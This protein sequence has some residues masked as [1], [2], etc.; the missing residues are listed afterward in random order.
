MNKLEEAS[1]S[2][3]LSSPKMKK[4]KNMEHSNIE[5]NES[6]LNTEQKGEAGVQGAATNRQVG[7]MSLR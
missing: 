4:K 6:A 2:I 3:K 1:N 5:S 7:R